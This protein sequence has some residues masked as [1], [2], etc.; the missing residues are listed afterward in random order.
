MADRIY[1]LEDG[2][3]SESGRHDELMRSGGAYARLFETQAQS[4]R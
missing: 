2:R 4:Y 3:V 1:L